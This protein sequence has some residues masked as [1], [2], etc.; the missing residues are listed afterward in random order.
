[1]FNITCG[2]EGF[3]LER[4][5]KL[6]PV[7]TFTDGIF[8]AGCCQAPKDI[9]DTVAQAGAAAAEALALIDA[10]YVETEPNTAHVGAGFESGREHHH[11]HRNA[12][13]KSGEGIF[14]ADDQSAFLGG[15]EHPVGHFR[16]AAANKVHVL[17]QELLVEL[18]EA[19]S[20]S[21]DIN[22][23]VEN[24]GARVFL[25]EVREFQGVHAADAGA[26]AVG[27][28]V[29]RADAVDDPDG[30]GLSAIPQDYLA[31]R[32]L[33]RVHQAFHFE[34]R[35]DIGVFAVTVVGYAGGI[36]SL[37]TVGENH[38]SHFN[39]LVFGLGPQVNGAAFAASLD[40]GGLAFTGFELNTGFG[41]DDRT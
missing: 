32:R 27:I 19:L 6:A 28:L 25:D 40:T 8:L 1:M 15:V 17:V 33:G 4:H 18:L 14:H 39:L 37:E 11:V 38:G 24:F 20:G 9:P 34:R 10:G 7:N 21:A 26:P 3:F 16:H 36:E 5:P 35:V 30:P 41:V 22:V 23:E 12:A 2:T 31:A 29:A 13:D